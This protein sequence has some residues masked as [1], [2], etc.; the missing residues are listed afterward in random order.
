MAQ[1][2]ALP[3]V[4]DTMLEGEIVEWFVA[5]GDEGRHRRTRACVSWFIKDRGRTG[6]VREAMRVPKCFTD[7]LSAR[8]FIDTAAY[9]SHHRSSR[10]LAATAR[11][12]KS[13][14]ST[15]SVCNRACDP[16]MSTASI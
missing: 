1:V 11:T 5:V 6:S 16:L 15:F 9:A 2:F 14:T 7:D 3:A 8:A 10:C 12:I 4:G 13:G